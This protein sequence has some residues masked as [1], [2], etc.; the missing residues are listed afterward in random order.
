MKLRLNKAHYPVTALGPGQRLGIWFQ[1]CSLRCPGCLSRDTWA[2][3]D[4]YE[5][6]PD[7]L[8]SWCESLAGGTPDGVTISGGEPFEQPQALEYLLRRFSEWRA[9]SGKSFDVLCYSG[10][11]FRKLSREF[12]NI[13][14]L[15][16]VLIPEP[17]VET[18]P[19]GPIWRGSKNQLLIP[20]S[21]LGRSRY[22]AHMDAHPAEPPFQIEVDNHNVWLIG[23]PRRGDLERM[24]L[25]LLER[26]VRLEKASWRA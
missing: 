15:L 10:L 2:A 16:D 14:R 5:I 26:G 20:L 25:Q 8:L 7:K 6:F 21:D 17:Y 24:T 22:L 19:D 12:P 4:G 13:L 23:V 9:I 18:L 1:G 11:P 3:R